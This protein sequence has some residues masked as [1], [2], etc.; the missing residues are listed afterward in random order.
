MAVPKTLSFFAQC[1]HA[2]C[3]QMTERVKTKN[4]MWPSQDKDPSSAHSWW[5]LIQMNVSASI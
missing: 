4:P 1:T 3:G 5:Q 2:F